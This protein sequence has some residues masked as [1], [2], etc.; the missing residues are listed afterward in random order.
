MLLQRYGLP[1]AK[2]VRGTTFGSALKCEALPAWKDKRL[3]IFKRWSLFGPGRALKSASSN[4]AAAG[5]P[6]LR[7][8]RMASRIR[9]ECQAFSG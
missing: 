8:I 2:R 3:Q 4:S 1:P 6:N 7:R 5:T 9:F